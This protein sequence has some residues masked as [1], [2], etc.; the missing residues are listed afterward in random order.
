MVSYK[1]TDILLSTS[2]IGGL[3]EATAKNHEP[4]SFSAWYTIPFVNKVTHL[5]L[6]SS[7]NLGYDYN[8]RNQ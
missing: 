4:V 2:H 3:Q 5:A 1:A 6:L 8:P 7:I